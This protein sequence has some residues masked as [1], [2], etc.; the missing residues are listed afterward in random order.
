MRDKS[1]GSASL[2]AIG[3][4]EEGTMTWRV[5]RLCRS[6]SYVVI[7]LQLALT[8]GAR[9]ADERIVME[10]NTAEPSDNQ[11]RVN[12]V[13]ENREPV[14]L[15]GLKLDLVAFSTDGAIVQRFLVE[16]PALRP[17]KTVVRSVLFSRECRQIG[18]ILVN[19]VTA[20]AP[21]EPGAC[22]DA[23]QLSSR[24]QELRFYK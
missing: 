12:F 19:D 5:A 18:A 1:R 24:L 13:L 4:G 6:W 7:A 15:Q 14:A 21:L 16:M 22:L 20:C 10:L 2:A 23:L 8:A 3:T 17:T 11:C 9:A